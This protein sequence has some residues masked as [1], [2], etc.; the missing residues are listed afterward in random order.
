MVGQLCILVL[1]L[2]YFRGATIGKNLIGIYVVRLDGSTPSLWENFG[3][4]GGY[5]AGL[6]TGLMG[7]LQIFWDPNRQAIQDKI[8]ETLVLRKIRNT[9]K[10]T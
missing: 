1:Y 9:H 10:V 8:S 7:F 2:P 3:R 4:Y 5:G 6:A